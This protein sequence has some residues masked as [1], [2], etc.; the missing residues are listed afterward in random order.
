MNNSL[1]EAFKKS[2]WFSLVS[3]V[4]SLIAGLICVMNPEYH[5][6]SIV[7]WVCLLIVG[8]GILYLIAAVLSKENRIQNTC[9]GI[10]L[11]VLGIAGLANKALLGTYLPVLLGFTMIIC[12]IISLVRALPLMKSNKQGM[13]SVIASACVIVLGLILLL[14]PSLSG[15]VFGVFAGISLI[16]N[17]IS[18][19]INFW[20]Y[21]KLVKQA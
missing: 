13:I 17:G 19:L 12:G 3:G 11:G 16:I 14:N 7:F 6:E 1:F 10:V 8:Y 20:Q 15:K 5:A 4:F 9:F 21:K 18:A 2:V